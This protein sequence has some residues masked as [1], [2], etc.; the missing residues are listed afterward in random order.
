M[1]VENKFRITY[2][3]K[4]DKRIE[5]IYIVLGELIPDW[6]DK[7]Y[8]VGRDMRTG[9]VDINGNDVFRGDEIEGFLEIEKDNYSFKGNVIFKDGCFSCDNAD[10]ELK[11]YDLKIVGNI[12]KNILL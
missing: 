9:L 6:G 5:H 7:W 1:K 12:Y 3:H 2:Y 8:V 10:F 4:D 11:H